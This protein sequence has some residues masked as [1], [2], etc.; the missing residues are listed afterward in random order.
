MSGHHHHHHHHHDGNKKSL[1]F[2]L[3]IS[4]GIA[5]LE[6]IGGY[7]THSLALLADSGHMFMDCIA[8]VVA[9]IA[10]S[11][12][13]KHT[14]RKFEQWGGYINGILL[15]GM[16]AW[17]IYEAID[18]LKNPHEVGSN[19]MMIIAVIGL[20][21]NV[22]SIIFIAKFGDVKNNVNIRGAYLH[23]MSDAVSSIGALLAGAVIA[24]W[25]WSAIDPIV[26]III[27]VIFIVGG[28]RLIFESA[29][30]HT[31]EGEKSAN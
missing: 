19:M 10:L 6:L 9:L 22:A 21:A 3:V 7:I 31:C 16:S 1:I 5:V 23:V 28:I 8:L 4:V 13:K 26:S 20:L 14:N 11:L 18:R 15:V 17:I 30:V 12:T 29:H 24:I 27:S 25:D 2:S